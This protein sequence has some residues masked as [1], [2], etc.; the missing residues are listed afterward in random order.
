M[1]LL[2]WGGEVEATHW[3]RIVIFCVKSMVLRVPHTHIQKHAETCHQ[4]HFCNVAVLQN[5]VSY[6]LSAFLSILV[7]YFTEKN[8]ILLWP[9]RAVFGNSC[10][11]ENV[12]PV[13][14]LAQLRDSLCTEP[15]L[16]QMGGFV[17]FWLVR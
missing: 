6:S 7:P 5:G 13:N 2:V 10:E 12:L 14:M 8:R 17:Y 16:M 4:I 1:V 3:L 11:N 15:N 9:M